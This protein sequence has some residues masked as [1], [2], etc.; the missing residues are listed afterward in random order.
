[1]GG[2]R[3]LAYGRLQFVYDRSPTGSRIDKARLRAAARHLAGSP[4][5]GNTLQLAYGRLQFV[6]DCLPTGGWLLAYGR[7]LNR[8]RLGDLQPTMWAANVRIIFHLFWCLGAK[9]FFQNFP[10]FSYIVYMY[11]DSY[12]YFIE[13]PLYLKLYIYIISL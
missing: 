3:K 13:F 10:N 8:A 2:K 4:T 12:T 5:G 1:M 9:N 6:F 11:I 7:Q